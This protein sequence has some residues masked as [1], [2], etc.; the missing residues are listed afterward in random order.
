[1]IVVA[2]AGLAGL[3]AARALPRDSFVICDAAPEAGGL[4]RSLQHE[5]YTFDFT[6]HLL[7]LKGEMLEEVESLLDGNLEVIDRRA[8]IH[9]HGALVDYPFQ[10]HLHGLPPGV[11]DECLSG[12]L[13]A[14]DGEVDRT[15]FAA[16]CDSVFGRGITRHFMRPYNEK[17]LR[18]RL[19][20][21]STDWVHYIPRPKPDEVKAGAR[22]EKL[23]GIG[24]NAQFRYPKEGGI[25][26]LPRA[27]AKDLAIRL[28]APLRSVSA[29]ER[30]ALVGEEWI[31]Y[32]K[33]VSS[34]PLPAL[35]GMIGDAPVEI[36]SAAADLEAVGVHCLNL[37]IDG[38]TGER[39]WIYFPESK[40]PFYRVGFYHNISPNSAPS[41]KSALYVE[42]SYSSRDNVPSTDVII[43]GL[44]EAGILQD[45]SMVKVQVELWIDAAYAVHTPERARAIALI[46]P[47]L[48]SIGIVPLSRYGRWAYTSMGDALREGR[49]VAQR[50]RPQ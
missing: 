39:H 44:V 22:G 10:V 9:T 14:V 8:A 5:G 47:Y 25:G 37:G 46:N 49:E 28:N 2:G 43:D 11:R 1:M 45:R 36:R 38:P 21:L 4:C 20:E 17:L 29:G 40:Y 30:R 3:S 7:H 34:V 18:R 48:E 16:W 15:N 24:Y 19:E 33:L 42:T 13:A 27:L 32:D 23:D 35:I 12:F 41:G 50:L 31:K 26:A 6:G